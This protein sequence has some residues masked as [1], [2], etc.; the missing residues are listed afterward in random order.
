MPSDRIH[1]G[2]RIKVTKVKDIKTGFYRDETPN[3]S[4]GKIAFYCGEDIIRQDT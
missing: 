2:P 3:A 4:S 1:L